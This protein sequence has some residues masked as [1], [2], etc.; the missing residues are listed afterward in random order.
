MP[1]DILS[2]II[3]SV[4]DT[5]ADEEN[6]DISQ[7]TEREL[8]VAYLVSEGKTNAEIAEKADITVR[9]VKAHMTSIFNKTGLRDRV[10]LALAFK[11]KVAS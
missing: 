7:L 2:R 11:H 3:M 9:T 5:E 4:P 1:P 8:E 6:V 10:A